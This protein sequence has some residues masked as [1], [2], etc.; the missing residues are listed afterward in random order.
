MSASRRLFDADA[1]DG[2]ARGGG[3]TGAARVFVTASSFR[4]SRRAA[5][6]VR[7]V[8]PNLGGPSAVGTAP[9][10]GSPMPCEASRL[11]AA[12][13]GCPD[14]PTWIFRANRM[15][16]YGISVTEFGGMISRGG[17]WTCCERFFGGSGWGCP[18]RRAREPTRDGRTRTR[19]PS[20]IS[21]AR[22]DPVSPRKAHRSRIRACIVRSGMRRKKPWVPRSRARRTCTA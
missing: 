7:A 22:P 10:C 14:H 11:P 21:R 15:R 4:A 13:Y 18:Q 6:L 5:R 2:A 1:G 17:W 3:G 20:N 8:R 19:R 9:S 12:D 16:P